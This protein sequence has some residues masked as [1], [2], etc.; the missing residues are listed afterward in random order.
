MIKVAKY[1]IILL[2]ISVGIFY[3]LDPQESKDLILEAVATPSGSASSNVNN[4]VNEQIAKTR[5]RLLDKNRRG[6]EGMWYE[7]YQVLEN[8]TEHQSRQED[9]P[10]FSWLSPMRETKQSNLK[11]IRSISERL[12]IEVNNPKVTALRQQ[13]FELKSKINDDL[14][15]ARQA[16]EDS[17]L[18]PEED[19]VYFWQNHKGD[20]RELER[21]K[22]AAVKAHR[23]EQQKILT[24]CHDEL[25]NLG[26][27]LSDQQ[28]EQLFKLSSGDLMLNLFVTFAQLNLLGE[29]VTERMQ[30]AQEDESYAYLAKRYYAVY[31]AI[32][33]LSLDIYTH[34][35]EKLMGEHLA[36][37]DQLR[38]KLKKVTLSTKKLIQNEQKT[39]KKAKVALRR[40]AKK[41]LIEADIDEA[42]RYIV[43]LESNLEVQNKA[44][45]GVS[46]YRKHILTQAEEIK[47]TAR[48]IA[49]RFRIA[50]NTYKTV[51][52]G[53]NQF[54]LMREGLRDLSNLQKIQVPAMVPLAG[55]RI[56]NHLDMIT[57]HFNGD[58]TLDV[59]NELKR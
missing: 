10:E 51:Q 36:R 52:I 24:Q 7:L 34:T 58:E 17:Y 25:L 11:K 44:L 54:D 42:Q 15:V 28:V 46:A 41:D 57:K 1:T 45:D 20:F 26:V 48:R 27:E 22:E 29:Y 8:L 40:S 12:L 49:R 39:L 50:E 35:R 13:Y 16:K 21:K 4:E 23:L 38:E 30:A 55:D 19:E 53:T 47:R 32:I 2:T 14:Q 18:A 9:L 59:S 37:I 43:Q 31:V 33:S 56:T 6:I 3:N 5:S